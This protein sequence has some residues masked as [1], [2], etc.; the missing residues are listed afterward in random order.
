MS[1]QIKQLRG[2]IRQIVKELLPEVLSEQ[3]V[4]EIS[5]HLSGQLRE[6]LQKIDDRQA[7]LQSFLVRNYGAAKNSSEK[8]ST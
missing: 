4:Q 7:D 3:L 6:G 5:K 2:Q 1:K 8:P